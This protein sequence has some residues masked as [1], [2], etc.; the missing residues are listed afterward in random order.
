M[1]NYRVQVVHAEHRGGGDDQTF[2]VKIEK[3]A[4]DAVLNARW[5]VQLPVAGAL[6]ISGLDYYR[7]RK[8][9]EMQL[10]K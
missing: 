3:V 5:R 1:Q 6:Q 9:W 4:L 10:T 8:I 7:S 2:A